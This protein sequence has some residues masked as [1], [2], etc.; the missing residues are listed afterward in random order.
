MEE[1]EPISPSIR[2]YRTNRNEA[3]AAL[4]QIATNQ[5]RFYLQNNTYTTTISG[6]SGLN[7][8][9]KSEKGYY[10]ATAA[11]CTGG[12]IGNCFLITV[13]ANGVQAAADDKCRSF[14]IDST[15]VKTSKDKSG[16]ASTDCW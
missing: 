3:R 15:G 6:A 14:A 5:E 8:D 13:T 9:T 10:D 11:A 1:R 4:L 16:N 2:R 12:A 7:A